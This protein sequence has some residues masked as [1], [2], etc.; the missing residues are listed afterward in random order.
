MNG[1]LVLVKECELL[2]QT[3]EI[4]P[5]EIQQGL[6]ECRREQ[7]AKQR[8]KQYAAKVRQECDVL[9]QEAQQIVAK[10]EITVKQQEKA[11]RTQLRQE[12]VAESITWLVEQA[13]L[14]KHLVIVLQERIG[15]QVKLVLKAWCQKQNISENLVNQLTEQIGE[16]T[17]KQSLVLSVSPEQADALCKIFAEQIQI[18]IRA[19]FAPW[20]AELSSSCMILRFDLYEHLER[21]LETC[22]PTTKKTHLR[23]TCDAN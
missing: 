13:E 3:L 6:A 17:T 23:G 21:L 15:Q 9:L 14:E 7:K 8:I 2:K 12:I 20:Q 11:W 22:V 1:F 16:A 19:D 18:R 5:D 4:T 10:A